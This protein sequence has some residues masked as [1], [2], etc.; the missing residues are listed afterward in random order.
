MLLKIKKKYSILGNG[1]VEKPGGG[2]SSAAYLAWNQQD[3]RFGADAHAG[4]GGSDEQ[5]HDVSWNQ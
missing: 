2:S 1:G 5:S 4:S 3:R